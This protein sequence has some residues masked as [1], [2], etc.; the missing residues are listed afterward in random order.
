MKVV[1]KDQ[2]NT[3]YSGYNNKLARESG[4]GIQNATIAMY[5]PL[6]DKPPTDY[7]TMMTALVEAIRFTKEYCQ[8]YRVFTCHQQLYKIVL[9]IKWTYHE[10]FQNVIPR[11]GC[12][13]FLMSFVE[14][15][16]CL[17][18]VRFNP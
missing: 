2:V 1:T 4:R 14:S 18:R 17:C 5:L 12:M 16:G 8:P 9:Y 15:I 13:H 3:E 6:I 7:L 11:H 10:K